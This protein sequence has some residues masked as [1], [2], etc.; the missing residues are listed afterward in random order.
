MKVLLVIPPKAKKNV[1]HILPPLGIGYISAA[2]KKNNIEVEFVNCIK[3]YLNHDQLV[4]RIKDIGPD[5][6]GYQIFSSDIQSV[7]EAIARIKSFN[8]NIIHIVGGYHPSSVPEQAMTKDFPDADFGFIGEAE[9]GLPK[10]VKKISEKDQDY[11]DVPGLIWRHEGRII[12]NAPC[13]YENLDDIGMP[14]WDII[15]PLDY[16][17]TLQTIMVRA[18][19]VAP[20]VASRGCPYQCTFCAGH[21]IN[22]RKIRMRS[23]ESVVAEMDY[24]H[25]KFGVKEFHIE[26]DNFSWYR[27]F[28]MKFCELLLSGKRKYYW[29]FPNGLRLNALDKELLSKM[30]ESGCYSI[31]VGVESGSDKV[32]QSIKKKLKVSEIK[33]KIKLIREVGLPVTGFFILGFPGE[34]L[35]DIRQ[36]EELI[37][38]TDFFAIHLFMFRPLPG[39]E[40]F[41][42]LV[43]TGELSEDY[44]G[45]NADH[46]SY[47]DCVYAPKSI[48]ME[49]LHGIHRRINRSFYL[50]PDRLIKILLEIK[51]PTALFYFS[52]RAISYM[53]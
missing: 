42:N 21:K 33:E 8:S 2:L 6:I 35:E 23:A 28:V 25:N 9:I 26:D 3:D 17:K 18:M 51:S 43:K 20:I 29:A 13:Y 10:L 36:T 44:L 39:T 50:R 52:K 47:A 15:N 41:E 27:D 34:T 37:M 40:A 45:Y 46:S 32:L 4:E 30:K 31:C 24:L 1:F 12:I 14:D 5:I 49:Q 11:K 48:T 22:G 7:K 53:F 19:P 16:Q 38:S